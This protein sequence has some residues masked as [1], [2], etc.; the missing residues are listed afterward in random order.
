MSFDL[1]GAANAAEARRLLEPLREDIVRLAAA[2]VQIKSV[3][4]PPDGTETAA[5]DVLRDF[6]AAHGVQAE[7]YELDFLQQ[8][9]HRWVRGDRKYT[10]RKNLSVHL[11]ASGCGKS[12]LL[13]GHMDTVPPGKLGSWTDDP[14]SGRIQNGRLYGLGSFDMKS[15][16]AAQAGVVAAIR[17]A[18]ISLS[19]DLILQ[20]VVDEEWGGGGGTLA[21]LLRG[22][23]ADAAVISEGTQLEILRATRGGFVVDLE[24]RAGDPAGYFSEQAVVSPALP[25]GRLLQWV[26][27]WTERRSQM[28]TS[29]PYASVADPAPV[30]VLAIEANRMDRDIP[31]SVPLQATVRIYFQFLPEEDVAQVLRTIRESLDE[32]S[33]SDTFFRSHPITWTP[34]YD[35][36][37]LG[38]ELPDQHPWT[39]CLASAVGAI[40]D[41]DARISA[42]PYPCDAF[43]L[44]REFGIPTLLFGPAGAGAHNPDEYAEVDS[45]VKTAESLLTATLAWC[46]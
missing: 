33:Q 34:L 41:G 43:L 45:I 25:L 18:G 6:L 46:R 44:Q 20:S 31:L 7:L 32:F 24:V 35:P 10:G 29:G 19:G 16:V 12:L 4:I 39:K 2:L 23:R 11:P 42:A 17:K 37:L 15:G 28:E 9:G 3:N 38:H 22:E 27:N 36:P 1:D 30:Q 13:N 5:Q 26:Q 14:W 40:C 8:S 21:A